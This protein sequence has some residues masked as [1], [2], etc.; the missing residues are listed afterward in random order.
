MLQLFTA[1]DSLHTSRWT[2]RWDKSAC[3]LRQTEVE[4]N[5]LPP[6]STQLARLLFP[7]SLSPVT[8]TETAAEYICVKR[9]RRRR[10]S[11]WG[12]CV[13]VWR[14]WLFLVSLSSN[15]Q[16]QNNFPNG[17]ITNVTRLKLPGSSEVCQTL[18]ENNG[19]ARY[20]GDKDWQ[21]QQS[22]TGVVLL[23]SLV[24]LFVLK[25]VEGQST[26]RCTSARNTM[27][28]MT[29]RPP[30]RLLSQTISFWPHSSKGQVS[31]AC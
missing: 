23:Q 11:N 1:C 18:K 30:S 7:S 12:G 14:G 17:C 29:P 22:L 16:L 27:I 25:R 15:H 19:T 31:P 28:I 2:T 5:I 9:R 10:R 4:K 8:S 24:C 13:P 21:L 6:L 20:K 26:A 3:I